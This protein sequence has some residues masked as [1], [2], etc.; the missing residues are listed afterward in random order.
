MG[1][2]SWTFHNLSTTNCGWTQ[3]EE[4]LSPI[5]EFW[6]PDNLDKYTI[7]FGQMRFTIWT[8]IS[9]NF[10]KCILQVYQMYSITWQPIWQVWLIQYKEESYCQPIIKP[11]HIKNVLFGSHF[12]FDCH[13]HCDFLIC[14]VK[15]F[16][17]ISPTII[18]IIIMTLTKLSMLI[19]SPWKRLPFTA[20]NK[21]RAMIPEIA[22]M[23]KD[24]SSRFNVRR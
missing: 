3:G 15:A 7:Q 13:E 14:N 24:D 19:A 21:S 18:I 22:F 11:E 5:S 8:N 9:Y 4:L 16:A 10:L 12:L 6:T 20:E 1:S 23:T 17:N 2:F